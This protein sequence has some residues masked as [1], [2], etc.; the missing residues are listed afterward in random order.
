MLA[1][2]RATAVETGWEPRIVALVCNWCTY[3][4]A[5]GAGTAR[6][7]HAPNVRIVRVLC[8]GRI[9]PLFILKAFEQ[10]ADGVIA[11]GCHPGDCHYVRGNLFARRRL[12]VFEKLMDFTGLDRRRLHFSWVSASEGVKWSR[13]VDEATRAVRE[14]GP[15]GEWAR[16][17]DLSAIALPQP[18]PGPRSRVPA[19]VRSRTDEE[20]RAAAG[21]LLEEGTVSVVLGYT[22]GSLPGQMVPT[23]VTSPADLGLLQWNDRCV[24]NLATYLP[25]ALEQRPGQRIGV[26]LKTCDARA[27]AGLLR[28][29]QLERSD[30]VVIGVACE[31]IWSGERLAAKC[32]ACAE[33][34]T[35]L[36]DVTV[37]TPASERPTAPDPRAAQIAALQALPAEERW[38]FWQSEF[39]RCL[40]CYACRA[41]CP[42]CYCETC[43]AEKTRPQWIPTSHGGA[44]NTAW[45]LTRAMHLAGRCI[46]CDECARACPADIRLDL[47]NRAVAGDVASRFGYT[48]GS[49]PGLTAPLTTFS[50]DDP[51]EFM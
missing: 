28:E 11:S 2:P 26:V 6:R 34:V 36:A 35:P 25:R 4:G 7:T 13:V 19:Q 23:F 22:A 9:D 40:R 27:L 50:P 33:A 44:G 12:S 37:G 18:G 49:D 39:D 16:P 8:T 5:D 15:L 43:I 46:D 41:V 1:E 10:G 51:D 38:N 32:Y 30:V 31:G 20:L 42:L 21:R 45:N 3:T 48:A 29:N 17:R 24:N 14:A 47:L